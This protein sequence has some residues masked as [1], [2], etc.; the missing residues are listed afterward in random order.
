MTLPTRAQIDTAFAKAIKLIDQTYRY[1]SKNATNFVSLIQDLQSP[2]FG[3]YSSEA[4]VN[5]QAMRNLLAGTVSRAAAQ[6]ILRPFLKMY[7]Q[8]VI[9]RSDVTSDA[10]MQAEIY[11]YY[12]DQRL[13]V[14]G[15]G[16]TFGSPSAAAANIGTMQMIRLTED[17]YHFP[18]E[19]A[20]PDSKR[21]RCVLDQN[22]GAQGQGAETWYLEGQ[23]PPPDDLIRSGSG[24]TMNLTGLTADNSL[25][26]NPDWRNFSATTL[27]S[28]G[29]TT[30]PT[31][32]TDWTTSVAVS[33]STFNLDNT[34]SRLF[35]TAPSNVVSSAYSLVVKATNLI[36]QKLSLRNT[37]I[38]QDLPYCLALVWNR[39]IGSASGTL[40]VRLGNTETSVSVAAQ[41]GWQVTI[42][43]PTQAW[44]NWYRVFQEDDLQI[45]I[46]WTRTG[47]DLYLAE[48]L[49]VPGSPAG[50]GNGLD[51]FFWMLPS[52]TAQWRAPRVGDEF[53]F[54]DVVTPA[55]E[56]IN[57]RT[58]AFAWPGFY[59][60][61][62]IGSGI[63][64]SDA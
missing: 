56:G 37:K 24:L 62:A 46:D 9:G 25:L 38:D 31:E 17:R 47:G 2:L 51:G 27:V 60:P 58:L 6:A 23:I 21:C 11:R 13:R 36:T 16:F 19:S 7:V 49:L 1:G 50:S 43:P 48:I 57:Q 28:G 5:A 22:T 63:T 55:S 33:G 59:L 40:K 30:T 4:A 20:S 45:D 41:T 64:F 26:S 10:A 3:D 53:T 42:C 15:R 52:S 35:R 32:L 29:L 8:D 44:A 12:V 34:P 39:Q 14:T 61:S 18:I 54:T